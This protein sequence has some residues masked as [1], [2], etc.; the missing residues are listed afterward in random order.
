VQH[1]GHEDPEHD[2]DR[3]ET[4]GC[5]HVLCCK[6]V[7]GAD[8]RPPPITI[9]DL[10]S[11]MRAPKVPRVSVK[12]LTDRSKRGIRALRQKGSAINVRV[13]YI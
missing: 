3:S 5:A 1:A 12:E 13:Y 6:R 7:L 2:N 8:G 11:C 9:R 4:Y 10:P